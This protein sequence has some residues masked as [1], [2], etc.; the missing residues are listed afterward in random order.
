VEKLS[1][2]SIQA[3]HLNHSLSVLLCQV[4]AQCLKFLDSEDLVFIS[5][6]QSAYLKLRMFLCVNQGRLEP[7][8][9]S[10]VLDVLSS[11]LH[12]LLLK[13]IEF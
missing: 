11:E 13:S 2:I 8:C 5:F 3:L 6:T 10:L 4:I 7:L 12:H 9:L 1:Q